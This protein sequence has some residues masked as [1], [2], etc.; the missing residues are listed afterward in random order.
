ML[1]VLCPAALRKGTETLPVPGLQLRSPVA[2]LSPSQHGSSHPTAPTHPPPT[3]SKCANL[4]ATQNPS[5]IVPHGNHMTLPGHVTHQS[6]FQ[7]TTF[8]RMLALKGPQAVTSVPFGS[9]SAPLLTVVKE[10]GHA[11]AAEA[12]CP[13]RGHLGCM[14]AGRKVGGWGWLPSGVLGGQRS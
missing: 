1:C 2:H 6:P 10:G 11:G 14:G 7:E 12:V 13:P 5:Y 4:T 9:F 8:P 3:R